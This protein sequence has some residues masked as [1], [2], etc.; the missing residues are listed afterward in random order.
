[1]K[2]MPAS[3]AMRASRRLSAQVPDQRSGT[4]VTLRPEEP[5]APNNPS[6]GRL[7][8]SSSMRLRQDEFAFCTIIPQVWRRQDK[9]IVERRPLRRRR[10]YMRKGED[11]VQAIVRSLIALAALATAVPALAQSYPARSVR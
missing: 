10:Q 4:L 8:P 3:S 9:P 6:L 1:M 7:L 2:S 11:A 5:L